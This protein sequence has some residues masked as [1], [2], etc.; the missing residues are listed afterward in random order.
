MIVNSQSLTVRPDVRRSTSRSLA[1]AHTN[2][3]RAKHALFQAAEVIRE[4]E[5]EVP[6]DRIVYVDVPVPTLDL[7]RAGSLS[8]A[9]A[10]ATAK[11]AQY[12]RR[13]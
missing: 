2:V 3:R 13:G 4:I 6:V 11:A 5:V 1:Y 7:R 9:V 10:L 8:R 12:Y